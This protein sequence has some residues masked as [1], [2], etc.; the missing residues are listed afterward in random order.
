MS[1]LSRK[2]L[3]AVSFELCGIL[4]AGMALLVMSSADAAHTF[5][6]SALAA[7]IAMLWSYAFNSSFE[8]WEAR[9][10]QRGRSTTRRALHAVL[11]EGGL[12]AVLLPVTAWWLSVGLWQALLLEGALVAVFIAYTYAFTWAFDRIFGLPA[13]AR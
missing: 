4:V 13:S 8:A 10:P 7:T 9:Q 5:S 12:M 2:I 3:Y 6:L 11:F 1:P